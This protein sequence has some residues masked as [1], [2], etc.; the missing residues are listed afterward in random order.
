VMMR[1]RPEY[2][3]K[4]VTCGTWDEEVCA[5]L[6][7]QP[8]DVLVRKQRY[9]GF[10]GTNLDM[11]LKTHN[12]K[13]CLYTGVAT[14]VCVATTLYDGF[15]LGYWPILVTDAV[16]NSGPSYN[17]DSTFWNVELNYGWLATTSDL[18]NALA[19]S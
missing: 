9:S 13:Y 7:P 16:N 4:F 5:Q 19:G 6:E 17:Q 8:E 15:F 1:R 12:I 11:I 14:N 18:A 10:Q 3:G 2:S